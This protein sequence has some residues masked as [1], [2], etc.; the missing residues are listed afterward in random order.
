[1]VELIR[2]SSLGP[3]LSKSGLLKSGCSK[4]LFWNANN[5]GLGF[6]DRVRCV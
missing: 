6:R 4:A 1:M 5:N 3:W 2:L